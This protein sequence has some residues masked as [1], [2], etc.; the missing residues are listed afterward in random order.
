MGAFYARS[1]AL[2]RIRRIPVGAD[3]HW[4]N[5]PML[6][7]ADPRDIDILGRRLRTAWLGFIRTGTPST[8]TPGG[9]TQQPRHAPEAGYHAGAQPVDQA[10]LGPGKPRAKR[11]PDRSD[12][13]TAPATAKDTL[14]IETE[15]SFPA[16][17]RRPRTATNYPTIGRFS[18]VLCVTSGDDGKAGDRHSLG[19]SEARRMRA[20]VRNSGRPSDDHQPWSSARA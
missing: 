5:A 11:N 13:V 9:S 15:R 20:V 16:W 18:N 12:P 14:A 8:D 17:L 6:G 19:R 10:R 3:A 4:A 2:R 7:G 1:P